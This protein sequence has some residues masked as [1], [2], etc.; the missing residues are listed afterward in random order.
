MLGLSER[1]VRRC[2]AEG[3]LPSVKI[4]GSRLVPISALEELLKEADPSCEGR[5]R[6]DKTNPEIID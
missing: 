1:A 5:P 4:G 3:S 6:K 2:I